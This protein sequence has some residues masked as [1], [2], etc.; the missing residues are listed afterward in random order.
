V[1]TRRSTA[2]G[3]P[4]E[5]VTPAKQAQL[6][7]LALAFLKEHGLL[8]CRAR[9]DIVA[10]TWPTSARQPEIVHYLDAFPPVGEGQMFA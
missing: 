4:V 8:E 10:I 6:T 1:K 2:A 3:H 5:A 7:R 9:F